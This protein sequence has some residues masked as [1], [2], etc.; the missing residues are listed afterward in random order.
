MNGAFLMIHYG[1]GPP[2]S[3]DVGWPGGG[4]LGSSQ[5]LR[6]AFGLLIFLI[7]HL[8][9]VSFTMGRN[10]QANVGNLECVLLKGRGKN[11]L[12]RPLQRVT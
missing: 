6:L 4:I 10:N 1:I 3:E 2:V 8:P 7:N 9:V 5:A 12:C 11:E